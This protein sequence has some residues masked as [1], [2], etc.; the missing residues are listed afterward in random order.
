MI[1]VMAEVDETKYGLLCKPED[2]KELMAALNRLYAAIW[3]EACYD[4]SSKETETLC[5]QLLDDIQAANKILKFK[6]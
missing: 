6:K 3:I 2:V 4:A 1:T 5:R